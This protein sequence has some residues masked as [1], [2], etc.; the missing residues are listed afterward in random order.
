MTAP[1]GAPA[2]DQV[3]VPPDEHPDYT[4][5]LVFASPVLDRFIM[6]RHRTRGWELPGGR[7]E[8]GESLLAAARREWSEE[9][10]M[11]LA[12]LEP[13]LL[14][15]R[16]DGSRGHL[17]LGA[18]HEL[19]SDAERLEGHQDEGGD[20]KIEE[21]RPVRRLAD[22]TPLAFPDDPY[23]EVAEAVWERAGAGPWRAAKGED[24]PSFVD[25]LSVHPDAHPRGH[26]V[27]PHPL[28]H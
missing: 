15:R 12:R 16:P 22:V 24:G 13:L 26:Q 3:W 4:V 5:L 9:T 6:A 21:V 10:S 18:V 20:E 28:G 19:L 23:A 14:H 17:F 25:R 27:V 7:V 2:G 8:R 1:P 11:P